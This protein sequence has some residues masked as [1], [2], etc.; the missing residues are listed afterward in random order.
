M[1]K[2]ILAGIVI[3]IIAA[4]GLLVISQ[5]SSSSSSSSAPT[6]TSTPPTSSGAGTSV[7]CASQPPALT[8]VKDADVKELK[9]EDKIIGSGAE[10]VAG[11]PIV[12]NYIGRL[13]D[14]TQFDASCG[15]DTFTF[16]LGGGQVIAGWD[17]GILG[18]KV[19]GI[20]RLIIPA[21]LG[22]GA[23]GAGGV[24]PPNAALVFDVELVAVQ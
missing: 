8:G 21:S 10:A 14:G 23:A 5:T 15:K 11:K 4:V 1:N 7:L 19:G 6:A 17:Q 16:N 18:M 13:T 2:G 22:Y 12:M 20:R 3:A 24:I 9:V